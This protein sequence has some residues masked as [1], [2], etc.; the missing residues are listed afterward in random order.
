[1]S[2][3]FPNIGDLVYTLK[4]NVEEWKKCQIQ[5]TKDENHNKKSEENKENS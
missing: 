2:E 5:D 3:V 1:M 4:E